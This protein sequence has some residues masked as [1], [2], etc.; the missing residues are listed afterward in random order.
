MYTRIP[1]LMYI[2]QIQHKSVPSFV[3]HSG[4]YSDEEI[5]KNGY[6]AEKLLGKL[7]L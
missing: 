1:D 4:R 5:K 7:E 2:F 3:C 6:K